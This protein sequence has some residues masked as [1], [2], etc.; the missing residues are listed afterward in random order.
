MF[1][2]LEGAFQRG[3]GGEEKEW[4]DCTHSEVPVFGIAGDWKAT[5]LE[6]GVWVEMVTR[7]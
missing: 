1:G 3:Q 2:N 4:V 7:P 5:A 6:A